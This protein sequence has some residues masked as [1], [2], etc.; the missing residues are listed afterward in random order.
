MRRY[1]LEQLQNWN[2]VYQLL[3]LQKGKLYKQVFIKRNSVILFTNLVNSC[4]K[5]H[6]SNTLQRIKILANAKNDFFGIFA[7]LSA[8]LPPNYVKPSISTLYNAFC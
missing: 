6:H 4:V 3:F 8:A 5:K 2:I 1:L 7:L